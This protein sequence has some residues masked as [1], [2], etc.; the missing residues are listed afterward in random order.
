ML[1]ACARPVVPVHVNDHP[2]SAGPRNDEKPRAKRTP[3][4]NVIVFRA[5]DFPTID[6]PA[7]PDATLDAALSGVPSLTATRTDQL[8]EFLRANP[9]D[10]LLMPYGSAFP[11]DAWPAI[12]AFLGNGGGLVVLGGAPFHEP[13]IGGGPQWVRGMR[14]PN[15]AHELH[16]GPAEALKMPDGTTTYALTLRLTDEKDFPNEHGS[17]GPRDAVVRPLESVVDASGT[18]RGCTLLEIDRLRGPSAG[19]RWLFAPTDKPQ[20]AG[21]IRNILQ[22]ALQGADETRIIP[23]RASVAAGEAPKVDIQASGPFKL[24][25]LDPSGNAVFS[26][27]RPGSGTVTIDAKLSPGLHRL[28]VDRENG[29]D[30][31]RATGGFW[32]KDTALLT[33]GPKLGVGRDWM[34]KDGKAFPIVGTTYMASDAHRYFLFEPNPAVWDADFQEMQKRGINFVRT[35]LWT[36]WSRVISERDGARVVEEGV[37]SAVEAFVATAAKHG[38]VVC[39]NLFAFLPP[40][41][42]GDNPYLDP[43]SLQGQKALVRALARRFAGVP[44]VHWDLINEPSY[45]PRSKLWSTKPIGDAHEAT[46]WNEWIQTRHGG[47]SNWALASLWSDASDHPRAVPTDEDFTRDPVQVGRHPRKARDFREMTE[48]AV[49]RWAAEMRATIR[50][51]AGDALVTLGQDEGGIYERATQQFLAN[52]LDYTSVHTWWKNDDLLWDGVLTKVIGK[53]SLHQET[54]LMRLEHMDGTPWRTP[55]EAA[56]LLERKLGYAF[57]ARGTGV[58]EWVWNINSYMPI[59]EETTIGLFRPDGTAK[60]ELDALEKYARFFKA[61]APLLEDFEPDPV[62]LIVPHAR[63]FLGM[64]GAIDATKPVV[65]VLAERFGI[66]PAA[67]SDLRID[68]A[69]LRDVKLVIVPNPT[70]LDSAAATALIQATKNGTRVLITGGFTG[71]SYGRDIPALKPL[72]SSSVRPVSM[73]EKT[74]WSPTGSVAFAGGAQETVLRGDA[75]ST[76][77]LTGPIWH[78]PLPLELAGESEPLARLLRAALD[79]AHVSAAFSSTS[80]AGVAGRVLFAPRHALVVLVNERPEAASRKVMIDGHPV[81]IR[82]GSKASALAIVERATGKIVVTSEK[83]T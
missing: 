31:K 46:A 55:E 43:K 18:P 5:P 23:E 30:P 52:A 53:P 57:A 66:V 34:T 10:V 25:V 70:V 80:E 58:V 6:A 2:P 40:Q 11:I 38:I 78:E 72:V 61:A 36:A 42:D 27:V 21:A 15:F 44:W 3:P 7:I 35:G 28:I 39:F 37:L 29:P 41:F 75:P 56:K 73:H 8:V 13:V 24:T 65:R 79:G 16:I 32:V 74:P 69:R 81:E 64:P 82:V 71:D 62:V 1:A 17:A 60:P 59:D 19:A 68:A 12:H 26:V 83:G 48:E 51:S 4:K 22:H 67:M 76:G 54:G 49:A 45:A 47:A 33:S 9:Y 77:K 50:A 14:S 20:G 63:A